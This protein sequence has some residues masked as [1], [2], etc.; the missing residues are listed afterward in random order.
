MAFISAS[1]EHLFKTTY[2]RGDELS[3]GALVNYLNAAM[4]ADKH[5]DFDVQEVTRAAASLAKTGVLVL[6]GDRLLPRD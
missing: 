5:D 6:E 2:D 4:P 1:V 3:V